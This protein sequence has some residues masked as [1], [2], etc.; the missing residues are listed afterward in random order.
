MTLRMEI[1]S[2]ELHERLFGGKGVKRFLA[3]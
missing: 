1:V 2:G 3:Y